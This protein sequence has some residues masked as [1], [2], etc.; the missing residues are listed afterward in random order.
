MIE[1]TLTGKL[2]KNGH[3]ANQLE[4]SG[5][6]W[7]QEMR[8]SA[9]PGGYLN[10]YDTAWLAAS[11][12]QHIPAHT[13]LTLAGAKG[14]VTMKLQLWTAVFKMHAKM[15]TVAHRQC[16]DSI[17]EHRAILD[18]ADNDTRQ[19]RLGRDRVRLWSGRFDAQHKTHHEH[20][21]KRSK[22]ARL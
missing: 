19:R 8:R 1:R 22:T 17:G 15:P 16:D 13:E 3:L 21:S 7:G 9:R 2:R 18:F 14:E 5:H 6:H 11:G 12:D 4:Q 10:I 20:R